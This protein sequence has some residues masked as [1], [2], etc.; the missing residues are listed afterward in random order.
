MGSFFISIYN[1]FNGRKWLLW[2]FT[3]CS[4]LISG[5]LASRI[6][7]EEDITRI[8]PQDKKIDQL[9][10]FLLN[11]KFADKLVIMVSQK[12]TTLPGDPDSLVATAQAFTNGLEPLR[13]D[14]KTI[15]AQTDDAMMMDFLHTVQD[16]LPVFLE[17]QDYKRIDSLIMPERLQQTMQSNYNTLISPAGLVFKQMIQADP[18]G[19]S[20]LGV[21]KLERLQV[22]DQFELYE[23]YVMSKDHRNLILFITPAHPPNETGKN[24]VFLAGLDKL[25]D[26]VNS[27]H[28]EI[29][30]FG[31]T[32]VSVGNA[33]QLR[34]DTYFTQGI[35]VIL[36]IIL[37]AFFFKKK[38]APL[39]VMLPVVFGALF[40][41][42]MVYLLKGSISVIALGAGCV[43][44]GIAVNYSLHVFNHYRHLPD[45]RLV[46]KDLAMP[47]T[48][49]SFTTVGGFLCLQ[50]VKS[51][52]L[53]DV[54][55]FAAFCLIGAALFSL[56]FLPH[57]IVLGK[58]TPTV[59]HNNWI[60]KLSNY[61]P[62]RNKY[63]VW[64]ILGLTV[65]FFFTARNVTFESD[66]M[67]MNFMTE[68]LQKS[69]AKLNKLYA[70]AAQSVYLVSEGKTLNEALTNR[71][72]TAPALQ[73][74]IDSGAVKKVLSPASLLFSQAEQAKR[75]AR[76]EAY[77]TAEKQQQLFALLQK[78]GE[79][80]KFKPAAFEPFKKLISNKYAIISP[81]QSEL[82]QAD[83]VSDFVTI[84]KN[85][86]SVISLLKVDP[87]RKKEV[88]AALDGRE[89][90]VI[91]DK[92]YTA[93]RLVE[94]I[95]E[96]F[97]TI[98]WMTSLLVFAAL[99]LS[100]GRIE[101]ALITFIPMLISWVWIL[102]I[103]GLFGI[104]FNIVNIILST[105][106]FGLGDDYSIFTMDGLQ[107]EYKTG[108]KHL[109]S[110]KSS[111][112]FSAITTILGLGVLIFAKHPSLRSIA[113]IAVIGITCVVVTSQ[114]LIPFLFNWLI[115]NR[116]KKGQRPP[117]TMKS[118][119]L[120]MFAFGYYATG[121]LLLTG[122]G[123]ILT[124]INPFNI[125]KGKKIYHKILS[126]FTWSLLHIMGNIRKRTVNE[127]GE[128]FK[129]PAV[130]ISNH[131]SFLD[132]LMSTSMHPNVILLTNE[133]VYNS[134]LFGYAVRM[135]DYYP[136]AEG[137]EASIEK[138]RDRVNNGYS[139]V[140]YP[141]GTRS[142]DA[143]IKRFHKGAFYLAQELNIDILP[144][145]I[146]GTAYTMSKGDFLLKNGIIT[147]K[148]LPR[149][150]PDDKRWGDNYSTRTKL[151]SK[152]F[153][154][155]Y[156]E[157]RNKIEGPDYYR[158][159]LVYQ[160]IYKGPVLEWYMRIKT[161]LEN[162][163]ALFHEL[164]PKEGKIMD[165]G[166][167]Y[168]FMS[169][170]LHFRAPNRQIL[171]V[172]YDEDKIATAQHSYIRNEMVQ[173]EAA[174]IT[175]YKL[176]NQDAFVIL[177]VLHYLQ[178][179]AQEQLLQQCISKLNPGGIIIVRD[180]D[181]DLGKR[182]EGTKMTELFSTR[183]LGFNKT[184]DKPLSFFSSSTIRGIVQRN[185]ATIEQID[186]TKYT[187]N[188]IFII[189]HSLSEHY[190]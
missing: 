12:D 77:W 119:S 86:A 45:I 179:D 97:N 114:V 31:A 116:V 88:Y 124:R 140:V 108:S 2:L 34:Q 4:F 5:L 183:L 80:Y 186:N 133:W 168:G 35:T 109:P 26:T 41:V 19:I 66:M 135:A 48:V 146:H 96:E 46:I 128:D 55:F 24:K 123:I 23:G 157:M 83:L 49:G 84:K 57:F 95:K 14:I 7:L 22:D 106:I 141:E 89:H 113:L 159:Q 120:S 15:H 139:I 25:I 17:E 37:I 110:F 60:D 76:W 155:E 166:C 43:V 28:T 136:V 10:Q 152:Y 52:M 130:I 187:S 74:L 153:K 134:P 56:I 6:K 11:A 162:N 42:A 156:E 184:G 58:Q 107:Q 127:H 188:V 165:I 85:T 13:S 51:P 38:R 151:V 158:E 171:G 118:W 164:L 177:D 176:E 20:W 40:S 78:E 185:G 160:Y 72:T 36:L 62:E 59:A 161:K 148:Y 53:Q 8:L 44:L 70:Y 1:F 33:E 172:D 18:V 180:G 142:T 93:N 117:W 16:H 101:L 131:Q 102:G 67:R 132:I 39:L 68:R 169:Y 111:I 189:K 21:K 147:M 149:I 3:L 121:A 122:A 87:A 125:E 32:A 115:T 27:S 190:A 178:P 90:T 150:K 112:I 163:Y 99:L 170:M 129:K 69:E 173:F 175:K 103:M 73:T 91:F 65:I 94:I 92:Q 82:L 145:V 79:Q 143:S 100:Y 30:Y 81:E 105:F 137:A 181:A 126:F 47:M 154:Q 64:G 144:A 29:S 54:G 182:H 9:Q 98:A 63:L 61:R 75:I 138:L 174:D 104:P 167:G 71:E 50:F